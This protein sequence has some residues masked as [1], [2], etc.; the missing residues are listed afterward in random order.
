VLE[1]VEQLRLARHRAAID[2]SRRVGA[3]HQSPS[4]DARHP[5]PFW[6]HTA[7]TDERSARNFNHTTGSFILTK[8]CGTMPA[9]RHDEAL[10]VKS[11][12]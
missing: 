8:I 12:A 1:L 2:L 10:Y 9:H 11:S 3:R 6:R 4:V 5:K 7:F